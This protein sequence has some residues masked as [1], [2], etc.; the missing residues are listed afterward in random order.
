[1]HEIIHGIAFM[2]FKDV[3]N[4]KVTF[5]AKLESGIFYCMCK[6]NITKK[7]ILTSL[8]FPLTI[9]GII[10]LIIGMILNNYELECNIKKIINCTKEQGKIIVAS[11][12]VHYLN[13]EDK[14][15]TLFYNKT[16]GD[17]TGGNKTRGNKS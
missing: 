9:I 11:G 15:K 8:L 4:K 16:R 10:T 7:V 3:Q 13:R 14:I 1:M 5:G 6:Q 17:K 2:L 12:D